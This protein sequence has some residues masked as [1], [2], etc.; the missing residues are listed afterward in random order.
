MYMSKSKYISDIEKSLYQ[1]NFW[2]LFI[3][4]K[5]QRK[6]EKESKHG[7]LDW[8]VREPSSLKYMQD[9]WKWLFIEENINK[10]LSLDLLKEIHKKTFPYR[11][12]LLFSWESTLIDDNRFFGKYNK[13]EEELIN[14]RAL[15]IQQLT[16]SPNVPWVCKEGENKTNW[17]IKE[18]E[19]YLPKLIDNYLQKVSDSKDKLEIILQ[20]TQDL[21]NIHIFK[22]GNCRAVITTWLNKEL[23]SHG[24]SPAIFYDPNDF[25]NKSLKELIIITKVGQKAFKNF[26]DTG[27]LYKDCIEDKTIKENIQNHGRVDI[28]KHNNTV[29][30][31]LM[32][33]LNIEMILQYDQEK[34]ND[35]F[36]NQKSDTKLFD[37]FCAFINNNLLAD[38]LKHI[39]GFYNK[40]H[41]N[42]KASNAAQQFINHSSISERDFRGFCKYKEID[43]TSNLESSK[44][45]E[46]FMEFLFSIKTRIEHYETKSSVFSNPKT[47][48]L[49]DEDLK[50]DDS[51]N[52]GQEFSATN[53]DQQLT[54]G[55]DL[56]GQVLTLEE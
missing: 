49:F 1:D 41:D 38:N 44:I 17:T 18:V 29:S 52:T 4:G 11:D 7:Y 25:D 26:I 39:K 50:S 53:L 42:Q 35:F 47:C 51:Q 23:I 27:Y 36:K 10:P 2:R 22:D 14:K 3:D 40:A 32:A 56:I 9:A 33:K 12:H 20:M 16:K 34:I 8:V 46:L 5:L 15:D 24:F 6:D 54:E 45:K 19:E 37:N 13:D 48:H 55:S 28:L 30:D 21:E 31:Y 43:N